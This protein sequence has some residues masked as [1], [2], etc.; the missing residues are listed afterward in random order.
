M[1]RLVFL[2]YQGP[3]QSYQWRENN[4]KFGSVL[5]LPTQEYF[6]LGLLSSS[7]S[8][9]SES[10]N[11]SSHLKQTLPPFQGTKWHAICTAYSSRFSLESKSAY[12]EDIWNGLATWYCL[13]PT[14]W[15]SNIISDWTDRL[16]S[17]FP[18]GMY[19]LRLGQWHVPGTDWTEEGRFAS[20]APMRI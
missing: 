16:W 15:T 5:I 2:S 1:T 10:E 20:R 6:P 12:R 13:D 17:E 7:L 4:A 19:I 11:H 18:R 9:D 8:S 14:R 3:L